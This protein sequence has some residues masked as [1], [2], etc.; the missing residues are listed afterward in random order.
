MYRRLPPEGHRGPQTAA[1]GRRGPQRTTEPPPVTRPEAQPPRHGGPGAWRKRCG[2]LCS[3]P[4]L[5]RRSAACSRAEERRLSGG[6]EMGSVGLKCKIHPVAGKHISLCDLS[7]GCLFAGGT[8]PCRSSHITTALRG[9]SCKSDVCFVAASE[10]AEC[11]W[12]IGL[13]GLIAPDLRFR[14]S[15]AIETF[16]FFHLVWGD[17][18]GCCSDH[19]TCVRAVYEKLQA[20]PP[21]RTPFRP[22]SPKWKNLGREVSP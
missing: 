6:L 15:Q 8:G 21:R 2:D 1:E 3:P 4:A 16:T 12:G 13:I 10:A 11:C 19:H 9:A 22:C 7:V 18:F 14:R 5:P 20:H 17:T